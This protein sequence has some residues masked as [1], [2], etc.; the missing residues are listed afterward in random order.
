MG[1]KDYKDLVLDLCLHDQALDPQCEDR[2]DY[3]IRLVDTLPNPAVLVTPLG[4]RLFTS[5]DYWDRGQIREILARLHRVGS[6]EA[7]DL[8]RRD[9][10]RFRLKE[11]QFMDA[12]KL[13]GLEGAEM[14]VSEARRL[15]DYEISLAYE[16]AVE[17]F[18]KKGARAVFRKLPANIAARVFGPKP[19][20]RPEVDTRSTQ[21]LIDAIRTGA[22]V[23]RHR[24]EQ[25]ASEDDWKELAELG[26]TTTNEKALRRVSIF[27]RKRPWPLDIQSSFETALGEPDDHRR[28]LRLWMFEGTR[29]ASVRKWALAE[30]KNRPLKSDADVAFDLLEANAERSDLGILAKALAALKRE[31]WRFHSAGLSM[32]NLWC[33]PTIEMLQLLYEHGRCDLCRGRVVKELAKRRALSIDQVIECCED[34]DQ[35]TRK[36]ARRSLARRR[37]RSSSILV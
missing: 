16:D 23:N 29:S 5:S 22:L 19:E 31:E 12:V 17:R 2:S 32:L 10:Y 36:F 7:G 34:S 6:K 25:L 15:E 27:F 21:E 35:W 33:K 4:E 37:V 28:R 24:F 30:L 13:L 9:F 3:M 14:L 18:G 20:Y 8:L 26:L 1:G 11:R